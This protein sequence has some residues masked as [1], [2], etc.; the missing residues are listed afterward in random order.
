M[1]QVITG[2]FTAADQVSKAITCSTAAIH[3][4]LSG[5]GT[6]EQ[7]L[8][9]DDVNFVDTAESKANSGVWEYIGVSAPFRLKCVAVQAA[10]TIDYVIRTP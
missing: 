7:Q 1:A 2:Q 8:A 6:V 5:T 10:N 4:T 3:L 9:L